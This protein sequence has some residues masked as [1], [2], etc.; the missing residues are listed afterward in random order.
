MRTPSPC[1]ALQVHWTARRTH[2]ANEIMANAVV[3]QLVHVCDVVK[4][5]A[6]PYLATYLSYF[7][8]YAA[9]HDQ[10]VVLTNNIH[11]R[12]FL[13]QLFLA[14]IL[15]QC[16]R[17]DENVYIKLIFRKVYSFVD[18][19]FFMIVSKDEKG[20]GPKKNPDPDRIKDVV[21][22]SKQVVF[23]RHGESD[24]NHIFNKGI[25]ISFIGRL[26]TAMIAESFLFFSTSMDSKFVDSPLNKEGID[27]AVEL[28]NFISSSDHPGASQRSLK[29]LEILRGNDG[30]SSIIV[31]SIL[32]RAIATTLLSLWPRINKKNHKIYLLSSL[33]EISRNVDTQSVASPKEVPDLPFNRVINKLDLDKDEEFSI[34][35]VFNTEY[36][37]GN[38]TLSNN[39]MKRMRAFNEWM[40]FRKEETIIV[41]GH[42][43]WFK[44]YF[45]NYLPHKCDHDAKKKKIANSGVVA[46]IVHRAEDENGVPLY[47]IE[48]DSIECVYGGFTSK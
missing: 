47:R 30:G 46:F 9:L 17:D 43:L 31:S 37:F 16:S 12:F 34:D 41:G 36:N 11:F 2:T 33:Q 15:I 13:V 22:T 27:Q 20:I 45:Q 40:F 14:I 10:Y 4:D 7:S 26:I 23:I 35:E 42:S 1:H 8:D 6:V 5:N 25:N 32:R 28:R 21:T 39:G 29:Y 44:S 48:P 24:W 3:D 38:K 18:S 19:V